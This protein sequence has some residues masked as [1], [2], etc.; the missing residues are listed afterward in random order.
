[1][2][3]DTRAVIARVVVSNPGGLLKKSMYVRVRIHTKAASHGLMAPVSAILRDD[4]NLP[5]V[6]VAQPNGGFTRR[7]ITL[8]YRNGD[9]F[10][11]PSGL[12]AGDRVVGDG[13]VF[14]QFMQ[15]Q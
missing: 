1:V 14:V 11:I 13:G 12:S 4:E 6:Y 10:E 8:G 2:N 5:F 7:R 9:Q 15:S 3:P